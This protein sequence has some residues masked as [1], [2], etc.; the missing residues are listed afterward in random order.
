MK[1]RSAQAGFTFIELMSVVAIMGILT[2]IMMP[3]VK[4]YIARAKVSEAIIALTT[5]R[6]TVAEVLPGR[7]GAAR[8]HD[9]AAKSRVRPRSTSSASRSIDERRH[10]G[11]L[12][13]RMGDLRI[14]PKYITLAPL[15]RA[16]QVMNEDDDKGKRC[17]AG[18]AG[19]WRTAPNPRS[20][21]ASFPAPAAALKV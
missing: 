3:S 20:T 4:N 13:R 17:S 11:D 15:S 2:A 7:R 5:C 1:G 19:R 21:S 6:T 9:G 14:A 10:Q 18:A 12:R 16:G 8:R